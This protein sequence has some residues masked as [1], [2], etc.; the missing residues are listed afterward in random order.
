MRQLKFKTRWYRIYSPY[1]YKLV[2]I[3]AWIDIKR[4]N[5]DTKYVEDLAKILWSEYIRKRMTKEARF[6]GCQPMLP[7][8]NN[9][10]EN[11]NKTAYILGC[12]RSINSVTESEWAKIS[13]HF[14]IGL[15]MFYTHEFTP[16]MYFSEFINEPSFNDFYNQRVTH[17]KTNKEFSICLP[18]G[19][20]ALC[21]EYVISVNDNIPKFY[22]T[23]S[24][25]INHKALLKKVM[26]KYYLGHFKK[27]VL[28]HQISNL[29]SAIN[30]CVNA[31]FKDIRLVGVDL[32]DNKYFF[33]LEGGTVY[34]QGKQV[35][36][37]ISHIDRMAHV[38]RTG[39]DTASPA[40]AKELGNLTIDEYLPFLQSEILDDLGVKLSATSSSSKLAAKLG[41]REI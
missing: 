4:W 22:T 2:R 39:H 15:N 8:K 26:S 35:L 37:N 27:G 20:I 13:N 19:Y 33:E 3:K 11:A 16:S 30:Y 40:I 7:R 36:Q 31:G 9:P 25:K 12:S 18:S 24:V 23:V 34:D 6:F 32:T 5:I 29:D 1:L 10:S 28:S 14:S 41:V 38:Q 17:R 21:P